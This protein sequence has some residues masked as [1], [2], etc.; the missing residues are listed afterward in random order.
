MPIILIPIITVIVNDFI[1]AIIQSIKNK[2]FDIRWMFR[3]WWMPS[4][5]SSFVWSAITVTFLELWPGSI[6]FMLAVVFWL[7]FMYDA[8]W[9]RRKAWKH[10]EI[11]NEMQDKYKLDEVLW[12][13][14]LEVLVWALFGIIFSFIL[15]KTW[16]FMVINF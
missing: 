15:W 16:L 6:E 3:S 8:R 1:K 7:L 9:I 10:A 11:L 13:T 4:W 5:H 12:H 14:S 2:K